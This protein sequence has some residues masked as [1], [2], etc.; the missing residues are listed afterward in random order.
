MDKGRS[1]RPNRLIFLTLFKRPLTPPP[2]PRFEH[3]CCGFLDTQVSLAPTHVRRSVRWLV[4]HTFHQFRDNRCAPQDNC[5][6]P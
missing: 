2:P 1:T 3:L 4:R 5:C 6:A